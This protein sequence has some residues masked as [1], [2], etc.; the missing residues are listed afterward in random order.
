[1][2][3][4]VSIDITNCIVRDLKIE[5]MNK[6]HQNLQEKYLQLIS[7]KRI[8]P[9]EELY[10]KAKEMNSTKKSKIQTRTNTS[11]LQLPLI[12][13]TLS[14]TKENDDTAN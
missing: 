8:R 2:K 7:K 1:M 12:T 11:S 14:L 6:K 9:Q 10:L 4:N 13:S 5:A 3:L